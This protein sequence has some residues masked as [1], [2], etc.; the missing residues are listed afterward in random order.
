MSDPFALIPAAR[1]QRPLP[2]SA[3]LLGYYSP[4][5]RSACGDLYGEDDVPPDI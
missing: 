4:A 1:R 2:L 5:L 3:F